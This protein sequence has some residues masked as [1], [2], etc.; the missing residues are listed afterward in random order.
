MASY[1]ITYT[2]DAH[3]ELCSVSAETFARIQE[4][5]ARE[6]PVEKS[7]IAE[8]RKTNALET[9]E[10]RR[11]PLIRSIAECN[12]INRKGRQIEGAVIGIL[13]L[14][15]EYI[16]RNP[17]GKK[18]SA[19]DFVTEL[20]KKFCKFIDGCKKKTKPISP[21]DF[22]MALQFSH[23]EAN[24]LLRWEDERSK[25]SL[26][27]EITF[28]LHVRALR[29]EI[30]KKRDELTLEELL[31]ARRNG[32]LEQLKE[33]SL[34]GFGSAQKSNS[35]TKNENGSFEKEVERHELTR[36]QKTMRGM[37]AYAPVLRI[38]DDAR[39]NPKGYEWRWEPAR[40]FCEEWREVEG[41]DNT[42]SVGVV[43]SGIA[44]EGVI[45]K[46]GRDAENRDR[47]Y[48][49]P[50]PVKSAEER[51]PDAPADSIGSRIRTAREWSGFTVKEIADMIAYPADVIR[52]WES[53]KMIPSKPAK[54][55]LEN[56]F[57][58]SLFDGIDAE[59]WN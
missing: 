18:V 23:E 51:E 1:K 35:D 20:G 50:F 55:E 4:F 31:N 54:A 59:I 33:K 45:E 17:D 22:E 39:A 24:E 14:H 2:V 43:L 44:D 26:N 48:F 42:I 36:Q 47:I 58:K 38:L 56:L 32:T 13:C 6:I 52:G 25:M 15:P 27:D 34:Q 53:G 28:D 8:I 40:V 30:V 10:S 46:Q 37:K 3:I 49:L 21:V 19:D 16:D 29:E 41:L 11:S 12:G 5:L 9:E 7:P 57:G